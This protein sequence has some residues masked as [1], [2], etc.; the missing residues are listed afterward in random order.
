MSRAWNR[1]R[2]SPFASSDSNLTD[3]LPPATQ[4]LLGPYFQQA[5]QVLNGNRSSRLGRWR[6][7]VRAI[8]RG[9]RLKRK[10]WFVGVN[11][12]SP[13]T[14]PRWSESERRFETFR[15]SAPGGQHVNKNE[16]AVHITHRLTGFSATAQRGALASTQPQACT[17]AAW[18]VIAAGGGPGETGAR[19]GA[20]GAAQPVGQGE[21]GESFFQGPSFEDNGSEEGTAAMTTVTIELPEDVFGALRRSPEEFAREMR[22]AAAL[23]WYSQGQLSQARAAEIAGLSRAEFIDELFRHRLPVVQIIEVPIGV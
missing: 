9:P 22:L 10:N 11:R 21:C 5:E 20:V 12:L 7:R 6:E 1:P 3:L 14:H 19:T 13:R 4:E 8:P 2:R 18:G 17:G 15:A 23:H 16:S